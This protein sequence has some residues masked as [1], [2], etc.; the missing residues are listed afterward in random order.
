MSAALELHTHRV[1][2]TSSC[3]QAA[4]HTHRVA[5]RQHSTARTSSCTQAAQ[6]STHIELHTGSTAHTCPPSTRARPRCLFL[7]NHTQLKRPGAVAIRAVQ[8]KK[9][10]LR[11]QH[12]AVECNQLL[13]ISLWMLAV[14][15][16]AW[17]EVVR[18]NKRKDDGILK[19]CSDAGVRHPQ[20]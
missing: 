20:A 11:S 8:T 3:T 16:S 17:V 7:I 5:H 10:G 18:R 19:G 15:S 12:A 2:H 13:P 14:L 4:Q 9:A 1:A 6:H